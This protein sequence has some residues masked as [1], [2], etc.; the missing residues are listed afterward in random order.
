MIVAASTSEL[1][2]EEGLRRIFRKL[3]GVLMQDEV[4]QFAILPGVA[5]R[6]EDF[7]SKLVPGLVL[8]HAVADPVVI[9]SDGVGKQLPFITGYQQ[10][11]R[12]LIGPI[13]DE[14]LALEQSIDQ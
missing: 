13:I 1:L 14:R 4:I 3:G 12:P 11:V 5:R 7:P 2:A 8:L 10:Q 9:R 6:G